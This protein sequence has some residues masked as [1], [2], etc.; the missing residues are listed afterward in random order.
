MAAKG[1][2]QKGLCWRVGNGRKIQVWE[3]NWVPSFS[4]HKVIS[5]RGMFPLDCK[6]CDF[7]DVEKRCWDL[8]LL[9][10]NFLPFKAEFIVRI[11][12]S[13][14]LPDDRQV[15]AETSNGFFSV[16]SAYKVALELETN[17]KISSCSDGSNLHR[18]WKRL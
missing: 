2:V 12:L 5:L 10:R 7:I 9:N 11:P 4:T 17:R 13:V 1:I 16:K 18:F 15:W 8:N 14:R 6:V 3:D